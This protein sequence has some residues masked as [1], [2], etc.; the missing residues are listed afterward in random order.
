[1]I[2]YFVAYIFIE[3]VKLLNSHLSENFSAFYTFKITPI[4]LDTVSSGYNVICLS[5]RQI[6]KHVYKFI[7]KMN[8]NKIYI[9]FYRCIKYLLI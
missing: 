6:C 5:L 2:N 8:A 3:K 4:Y 9:R 1:M 7:I